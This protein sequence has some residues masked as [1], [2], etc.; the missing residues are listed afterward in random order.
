M[1]RENLEDLDIIAIKYAKFDIDSFHW[2]T[3]SAVYNLPDH[4]TNILNMKKNVCR[5]EKYPIYIYIY[6]YIL[7]FVFKIFMKKEIR[8]I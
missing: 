4:I 2:N 5:I 6:I 7:Q 8:Y 1:F 3:P